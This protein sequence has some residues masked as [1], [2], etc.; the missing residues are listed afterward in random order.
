MLVVFGVHCWFNHTH[1][2]LVTF[3]STAALSPVGW[4]VS[5]NRCGTVFFQG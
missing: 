2:A 4:G 1:I 5:R 3:I